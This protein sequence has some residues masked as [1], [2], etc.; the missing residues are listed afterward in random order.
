MATKGLYD[1]AR[2]FIE[3]QQQT[4]LDREAIHLAAM[5]TL[6]PVHIHLQAKRARVNSGVSENSIDGWYRKEQKQ[7]DTIQIPPLKYASV[8]T[9]MAEWQ[10]TYPMETNQQPLAIWNEIRN[11]ADK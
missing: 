8:P 4:K 1:E 10:S 11:T 7:M 9:A 6:Q 5:N 3:K 2:A